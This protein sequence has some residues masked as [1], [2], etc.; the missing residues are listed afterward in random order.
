[1]KADIDLLVL[2]NVLTTINRERKKIE[3]HD[4]KYAF[5]ANLW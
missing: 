1:M 3:T 5:E 2:E 4:R